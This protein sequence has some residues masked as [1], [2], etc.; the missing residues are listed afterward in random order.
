MLRGSKSSSGRRHGTYHP[1]SKER[2]VE[3]VVE[4]CI[5]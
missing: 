1:K 3:A 4:N 5:K 2:D